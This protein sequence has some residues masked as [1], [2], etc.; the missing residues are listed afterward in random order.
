MNKKQEIKEKLVD[1]F[2]GNDN[3]DYG[4]DNKKSSDELSIGGFEKLIK[5]LLPF[6]KK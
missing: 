6:I 2:F 1:K 5:A 3:V 4:E